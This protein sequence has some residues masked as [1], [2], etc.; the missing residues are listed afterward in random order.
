MGLEPTKSS[1]WK[2]DAITNYANTPYNPSFKPFVRLPLALQPKFRAL[3]VLF[4][5]LIRGPRPCGR[6]TI[7]LCFVCN[8]HIT[9]FSDFVGPERTT[10]WPPDRHCSFGEPHPERQVR[11]SL[12]MSDNRL[13]PSLPFFVFYPYEDYPWGCLFWFEPHNRPIG[14]KEWNRTT[15]LVLHIM[16]TYLAKTSLA[17]QSFAKLMFFICPFLVGA[18]RRYFLSLPQSPTG[19]K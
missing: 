7:L 10:L 18:T 9:R 19:I 5:P 14:A 15:D 3:L 1:A 6:E 11:R 16:L 17:I 4:Y 12:R 8:R 2:A 13:G